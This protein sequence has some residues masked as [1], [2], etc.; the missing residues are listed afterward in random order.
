MLANH[1]I[2][3]ENNNDIITLQQQANILGEQQ[4]F[5]KNSYFQYIICDIQ[6]I[7]L[8]SAYIIFRPKKLYCKEIFILRSYDKRERLQGKINFPKKLKMCRYVLSSVFLYIYIF[9]FNF[10]Q[11]CYL[12]QKT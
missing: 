10:H 6:D 3:F 7:T 9:F 4:G 8:K 1:I 5:L 2:H 12:L 11:R